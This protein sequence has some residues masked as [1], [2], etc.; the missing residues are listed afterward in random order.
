MGEA[1][2]ET[3]SNFGH[4]ALA[5][6]HAALAYYYANKAEIDADPEAEQSEYEALAEQY[7]RRSSVD[8]VS[9]RTRCTE[10]GERASLARRHGADSFGIGA[11]R[12]T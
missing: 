10:A 9:M 11:Y 4:L 5:Q 6:V 8:P 3:A 2:E 1:P 7:R 12:R